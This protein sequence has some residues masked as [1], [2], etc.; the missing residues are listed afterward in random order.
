MALLPHSDLDERGKINNLE[1]GNPRFQVA[2]IFP[3]IFNLK[4]QRQRV[5]NHR[6]M[7]RDYGTVWG[8]LDSDKQLFGNQLL[9]I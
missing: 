1:K 3:V 9:R 7:V 6:H 2:E 8:D 4:T 5:H